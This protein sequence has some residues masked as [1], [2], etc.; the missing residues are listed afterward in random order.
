MSTVAANLMNAIANSGSKDPKSQGSSPSQG[1]SAEDSS[2]ASDSDVVSPGGTGVLGTSGQL[3]KGGSAASDLNTTQI[4]AL[5]EQALTTDPIV[6]F[7]SA[8]SKLEHADY[9]A[10]I[11]DLNSVLLAL[12][13]INGQLGDAPS[14]EPLLR[15]QVQICVRYKLTCML[16][17]EIKKLEEAGTKAVQVAHMSQFL[18]D[19][20]V[21][22]RH[23]AVLLRMAMKK[24][25]IVQNYGFAAKCLSMLIPKDVPDKASLEKLLED[26]K[27]KNLKD[28]EPLPLGTKLCFKLLAKKLITTKQPSVVCQLCNASYHA[29]MMSV[30]APCAYCFW[31]GNLTQVPPF[32]STPAATASTAPASTAP[33]AGSSASSTSPTPSAKITASTAAKSGSSPPT[34]VA[35]L[36]S[37]TAAAPNASSSS[38]SAS[39]AAPAP[40][41]SSGPTSASSALGFM[42]SKELSP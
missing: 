16:L 20:A 6:L 40:T 31:R 38:T 30:A 28:T 7:T 24:N 17:C 21:M 15:K 5:A 33:T 23:R 34:S 18:A 8:L 41:P 35:K 37:S 14:S 3:V 12:L 19:I 2:S 4:L 26:C 11:L 39:S 9:D 29:H 42:I 10:C 36:S 27:A 22:P 32:A 1:L 25:L 13:A